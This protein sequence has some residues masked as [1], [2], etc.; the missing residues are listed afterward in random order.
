MPYNPPAP[1]GRGFGAQHGDEE[2]GGGSPAVSG[3]GVDCPQR[4]SDDNRR[5]EVSLL[6]LSTACQR[7]HTKS[8]IPHSSLKSIFL[9]SVIHNWCCCC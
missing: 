9:T 6:L 5:T 7:S 1:S 4:P 8:Q 3:K 2:W